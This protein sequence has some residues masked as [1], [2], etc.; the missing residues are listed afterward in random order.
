MAY[1]QSVLI[2]RKKMKKKKCK[3]CE[4]KGYIEVK[5]YP[6]FSKN[7]VNLLLD[8][9]KTNGELTPLIDQGFGYGQIALKLVELEKK[10]IVGVNKE[11]I[12]KVK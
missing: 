2:R 9:V 8:L 6:R 1:V 3:Y 4:G 5:K 12:L 11:G 7:K 10:G